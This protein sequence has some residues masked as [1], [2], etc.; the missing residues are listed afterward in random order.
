MASISLTN[1]KLC[2]EDDK[3]AMVFI[4]NE[5]KAPADPTGVDWDSFSIASYPNEARPDWLHQQVLEDRNDPLTI[6]FTSWSKLV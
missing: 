6:W 4:D 3:Q 2:V 1:Y 5:G